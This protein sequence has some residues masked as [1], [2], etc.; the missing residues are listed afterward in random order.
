MNQE[1]LLRIIA[2]GAVA[3][4]RAASAPALVAAY[5]R[6]E[7][8][9]QRADSPFRFLSTDEAATLLKLMA[10]GELAADKLPFVPDRIKLLPLLGRAASGALVGAALGDAAGEPPATGAALGAA[11]AVASTFAMYYL[12]RA[13]GEKLGLPDPLLAVVEDGLALRGGS[14]VLGIAPPIEPRGFF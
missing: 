13:G 6:Q 3:G 8:R 5:L 7:K 1:T 2:L 4:M 12:R 11:A 10:A 9:R 14:S